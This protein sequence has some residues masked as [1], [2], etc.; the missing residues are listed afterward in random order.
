MPNQL[1]L[2]WRSHAGAERSEK[3][4][5]DRKEERVR[6]AAFVAAPTGRVAELEEVDARGFHRLRVVGDA[7]G[8]PLGLGYVTFC[9]RQ[10]KT[11]TRPAEIT[12]RETRG[13]GE[14]A[15]LNMVPRLKKA[16]MVGARIVLL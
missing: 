4:Y 13:D 15:C 2:K 16:D 5:F 3:T 1:K 10:S 8:I 14:W 9:L 7:V 6:K 11:G 12:K